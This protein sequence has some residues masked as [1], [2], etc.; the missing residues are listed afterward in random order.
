MIASPDWLH[1][2]AEVH[3]DRLALVTPEGRWSF[4]QLDADVAR[5]AGILSSMKIGP[6]NR[7]AYR[8]PANREQVL[9]AHAL[10]RLHAVLI[11]L[12]TRLTASELEPILE[13]VDPTL[14]LDGGDPFNWPKTV[15][16]L[17]MSSLQ[18]EAPHDPVFDAELRFDD[19]HAVVYT[20]GTTGHPKGVEISVANQ[21]WSAVGFALNSGLDNRDRW[22]HVMPLFHVAGLTILFRSAIHGSAVVLEPRFDAAR[23]YDLIQQESCTLLSVVPTM[24]HRLLELPG[25]APPA[26]RL[27]LLGGAPA[28]PSL[29][30]AARRR[31]Y[32]VVPTYGMTE[33]SS[34]VVTMDQDQALNRRAS[35]GHPNL[36]TLVRIVQGGAPCPTG[37]VGEVWV[38]GPAVTRG[39]WRNPEATQ[40][41]FQDGWLKTGDLGR[42]DHD[43][44]LTITD[45]LDDV[46]IRGGENIY[47][48]EVENA[49]RSLPSIRDV[50]VFGLPDVEWGQRVAAAIVTDT[51]IRLIDVQ[52]HLSKC[53]ASYKMPSMYYRIASIPRNASGKILRVRLQQD[54]AHLPKWVDTN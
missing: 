40:K 4:A 16:P 25:D 47:P 20:S 45:R 2:Q 12:N 14:V 32:P 52:N 22:L 50:V 26:L 13:N 48:S 39:Y 19:L 17:P 46:I 10:T 34:Q 7:V 51:P 15:S 54:A 21:W 43:G 41:A 38:K 9:L 28:E 44:Y 24:M 35:S 8:L 6:G 49:L 53:L 37:E 27:A 18:A 1:H 23:S 5:L 29:I 30:E 36:P 3:P 31:G 42:L 33:T 11:P